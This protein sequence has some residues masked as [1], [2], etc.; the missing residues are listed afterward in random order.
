MSESQWGWKGFTQL[1]HIIVHH[2]RMW[3]QELKQGRNPETR[4][5]AEAMEGCCLLTYSY[6]LLSLFSYR[7]QDH[8]HRNN[9]THVGL[10][11]HTLITNWRE[12]FTAES[13][14]SIFFGFG[15]VLFESGFHCVALAVLELTLQTG[16]LWTQSDLTAS[17]S[18]VLELKACATTSWL[19]SIFFIEG[20]FF[21][22]TLGCN[23]LTW[24]A[25]PIDPLSHQQK[26]HYYATTCPFL[27][28]PKISH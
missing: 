12:Y 18:W 2:Q 22:I 6:D 3:R 21:Q 27:F 26:H 15:L 1:L 4:T 7:T 16:W 14:G 10:G 19:G 8:Q 11:P 9:P 23:K 28:I 25:S 5:D 20:P 24:T 13:H 17:V